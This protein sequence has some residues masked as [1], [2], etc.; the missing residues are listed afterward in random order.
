MKKI[1]ILLI[2]I[3]LAIV[4]MSLNV[5][6]AIVLK[7]TYPDIKAFKNNN[8]LRLHVIANSNSTRDQ[9]IKRLIRDKVISYMDRYSELRYSDLVN[10]LEVLNNY[11]NN[12]IEDEGVNYKANIELGNFYFPSR[13]YD[14]LSLKAGEYKALRIILGQGEGTNWWCVLLPPLCLDN[15]VKDNDDIENAFTQDIEFRFKIL[16]WLRKEDEMEKEDKSE[17]SLVKEN[18]DSINAFYYIN[19]FKL[20]LY[21]NKVDFKEKIEEEVFIDRV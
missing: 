14:D 9:Y 8:L 16:D 12:I 11:I 18:K 20:Y 17:D 3:F 19:D 13:T 6:S 10:E 1:R 4:L 5:N 7:Q 2:V 15:E 21:E